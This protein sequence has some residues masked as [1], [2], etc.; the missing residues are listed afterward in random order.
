MGAI[1]PEPINQF[2]RLV[3]VSGP[4]VTGLYALGS[5]W[6]NVRY[7]NGVKRDFDGLNCTAAAGAVLIDAHTGGRITS[8]PARIRN[9]QN[10]WSGGIGWDDVNVAWGNLY[11]GNQLALPFSHDWADVIYSLRVEKRAVGIQY[12]YDQVPY[13]YQAQKGG[14]FDHAG[15]LLAYRSSDSRVLHYDPLAKHAVWVPQSAL[16]GAV[17]KLALVQ[18]GTRS[19]LFVALTRTLPPRT[20]TSLVTYRYGGQPRFR[21]RY[22]S[23]RDN[24]P[25]RSRPDPN[26]PKVAE[27]DHRDDFAARQSAYDGRWMG[28]GDGTRWAYY[29]PRDEASTTLWYSGGITGKEVIE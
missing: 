27:L 26:A 12:D 1:Y 24:L 13:A 16:R 19:R 25:V 14:T 15:V 22:L 2:N 6:D 20:S 11:P 23:R 9:A 28:T 18:R 5:A 17:E 7:V 10:D 3:H 29:G 8:N 4:E 21:G